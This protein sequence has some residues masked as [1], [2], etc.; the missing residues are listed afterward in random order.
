MADL[1]E[2]LGLA[3][4]INASADHLLGFRGMRKGLGFPALVQLA[5]L[6]P[7]ALPKRACV[8][9]LGDRCTTEEDVV[10]LL[11]LDW[12]TLPLERLV[13][14]RV[15]LAHVRCCSS[16]LTRGVAKSFQRSLRGVPLPGPSPSGKSTSALP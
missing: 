15:G 13:W 1:R 11:R 16:A 12:G 5:V 9:R 7:D 3:T 10:V 8:L 4:N 6:N 2:P 14:K